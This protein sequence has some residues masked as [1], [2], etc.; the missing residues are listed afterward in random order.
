MPIGSFTFVPEIAAHMEQRAPQSVLDLGMGTGFYGAVVRQWGDGGVRPWRTRLI[1]VE[2]HSAYRNPLWEL[3]DVVVQASLESYL[4]TQC[5]AYDL[6]LLLDVIEHF[7]PDVGTRVLE[8]AM[9]VLV[10]GGTLYVGTPAIFV[11]Q[12]AAH[13]NPHETHR[14]LWTADDFTQRGFGLL[15]DGRRCP[16]GSQML[17]A[18]YQRPL[19]PPAPHLRAPT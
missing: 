4:E 7:E 18:A 1:G 8:R 10:P 5:G 16:Y 2:I 9:S 14:A 13:G 6:V 15:R 3:Y 12:G 19:D 17:L 11:P